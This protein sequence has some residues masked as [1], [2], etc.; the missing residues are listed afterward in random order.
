MYARYE[1][2]PGLRKYGWEAHDG[3]QYGRQELFDERIQ[4]TTSFRKRFCQV[5]QS[6]VSLVSTAGARSKYMLALEQ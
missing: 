1:C 5:T 2:C 3:E 6:S 4:L